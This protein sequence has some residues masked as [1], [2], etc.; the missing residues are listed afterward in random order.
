M[1]LSVYP[2]SAS[3]PSGDA[4][5]SPGVALISNECVNAGGVVVEIPVRTVGAGVRRQVTHDRTGRVEHVEV[6][7]PGGVGRANSR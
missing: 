3:G 5:V 4:G 1:S 2:G 6:I 7:A